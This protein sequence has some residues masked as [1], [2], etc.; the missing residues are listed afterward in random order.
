[1][2]TLDENVPQMLKLHEEALSGEGVVIDTHVA[3]TTFIDDSRE[4]LEV[5]AKTPKDKI[6]LILKAE[7]ENP[8]DSNAVQVLV[9]VEGFDKSRKIGY[10]PKSFSET[11]SYVINHRDDYKLL[12]TRPNFFG[13]FEEKENIG[14]FF[15]LKI[16]KRG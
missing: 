13:G 8:F 6:T 7:P 10:I 3:G 9:R 14:V 2:S 4:L 11:I 5:L 16:L 15:S 12:I 1:M